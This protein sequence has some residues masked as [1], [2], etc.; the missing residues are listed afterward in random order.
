MKAFSK[1]NYSFLFSAIFL[2]SIFSC[3][4]NQGLK[5]VKPQQGV[6][7]CI[8]VR[9]FADSNG[10]GIGDLNG[11]ASKLDY[12]ENLGVSGIWLLP[13]FPSHSYHGYDVD[14]YYNVNGEY[15]T[16]SD[17]ENLCAKCAERG[18]SVILDLPLNHSS[19]HN[20][21]FLQSV[22][23][24][25]PKHSWYR[26]AN[27]QN[28]DIN[29]DASIWQHKVWNR[30]G[31]KFYSG[32]YYG[33][34]PDFNHD[35][36]EVR[37]EFKRIIKFWLEKGV[38]GFRF[39]AAGQIYNS[40][41]LPVSVKDGQERA[42]NFWNEICSYTK[43]VKSDAFMVGEVW[44]SNGIRA[45]Y[46]RALPSTFHFDLGGKII[47]AI[48]NSDGANNSIA[49]G[50]FND[51]ELY[52]QKN[53][54]FIDAP[55]LTNHDQNRWPLQF[56][57]DERC[58]KLAAAMYLFLPGIP[59]VYYGEEIAM[60]GAKPDEQ[61]RTPFIWSKKSS[62][63]MQ[64][65]WID[66]KYN[67]NTKG[68]DEQLKDKNSVLNFYKDAIHFRNANEIFSRGKFSPYETKN[69]K[70]TSW[71]LEDGEKKIFAFFNLAD[72]AQKV[73]VPEQGEGFKILF[74][75]DSRDSKI[76]ENE[77]SLAPKSVVIFGN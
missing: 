1:E 55:F 57:N 59:F 44:E 5:I 37:D 33:G 41:K 10:D 42:V 40:L 26:W 12:L 19:V 35:N 17:L 60:N 38:S 66:S 25:N 3:A 58:V 13:I 73:V 76:R 32:L 7:Y 14:D 69:S 29:F 64:T 9:S 4:E 52:A 50:L 18:I 46:M 54:N 27:A 47:N 51:Y 67:A 61:I 63:K 39:D 28:S 75:S 30:R 20:E 21:W 74:S 68:A 31:E 71:T 36:P 43:S 45:E 70:I 48:K 56:K 23:E 2:A 62:E 15:G 49:A 72:E 22:D 24:R 8:F 77:I 6:Y 34:M 65:N 53:P 11:I 16:I